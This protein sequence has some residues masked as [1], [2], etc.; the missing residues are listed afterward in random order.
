MS[1]EQTVKSC[2]ALTENQICGNRIKAKELLDHSYM[3]GEHEALKEHMEHNPVQQTLVGSLKYGMELVMSKN[4]TMSEVAPTMKMLLWNGAK[5]YGDNQLMKYKM[6]PYHAICDSTDDHHELLKLLIKELGRTLVNAKDYKDCTALM[7]AVQN[8]NVKCVESLIAN[9]ADVNLMNNNILLPWVPNLSEMMT[10]SVSPLIHSINMLH[11]NSQCSH[12]TVMEIFDIL[13]ESGADVNQPCFYQRRT[14]V[15]YAAVMG[16]VNCVKKLIQKGA[17]V[18]CAD[19][20]GNLLC[21]LA[22]RRG[23]VELLKYLLRYTNID[24]N[25]VNDMGCSVLYCAVRSG[26]IEAVRYLLSLGVK[27]T[28]Y[29]PKEY[30]TACK[31]C[32]SKLSWHDIDIKK[33]SF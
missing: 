25:S 24:K 10:D 4:R 5:W 23:N 17:E 15:M 31:D 28:S 9:G 29:K 16:N 11:P 13:L 2:S 18:D 30:V 1:S 22:A 6:T 32:R 3:F 21:T 14:P 26:N 27:I 7:R 20:D 12:D 33:T 8:A 19:K